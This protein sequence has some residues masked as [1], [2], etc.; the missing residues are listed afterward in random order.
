MKAAAFFFGLILSAAAASSAPCV[1]TGSVCVE[2]AETRRVNGADVHLDCWRYQDSYTCRSADAIGNCQ[3]LRDAGCGQVGSSCVSTDA[4][5]TCLMANYVYSCPVTPASTTQTTVCD[6]SFCQAGGPGCFD[7]SRTPDADFGQAA[8]MTEVTR[9][10]G[11]YGVDSSRVE[12]FKGYRDECTVK[13]LGGAVIKSCCEGSGGGAGY[14]NHAVLLTALGA[15]VGV[16]GDAAKSAVKTGSAYVYDALFEQTDSGLMDK[17][18][19]AMNNWASSLDTNTSF[20]AYGFTFS[21]SI[22]GGFAFTG[23]DPYSFAASVAIQMISEWLS[24]TPTEQ[25][26]ALKKGQ[27][28]CVYVD[29]YCSN[30]IPIVNICIEKKEVNCCFNSVLAKIVNRQGRFQLGM[31]ANQCGGFNQAQIQAINFAAIDFTEFIASIQ[32]TPPSVT[33]TANKVSTTVQKKV[34]DY[35]HQ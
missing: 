31:P 17:G 9:E 34:A 30:K 7:T 21:Y 35:Y 26:Y 23:Y 11:V 15:G 33:D 22:E 5:S 14:S 2:P 12:I 10:A 25:T 32:I 6:D 27:N 20:G 29:S 19:S 24:C 28:L 1:K 18:L 13:V 8:T 16:A 3:P 4:D